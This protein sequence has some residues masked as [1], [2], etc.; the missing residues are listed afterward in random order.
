MIFINQ[1]K[2]MGRRVIALLLLVMTCV[3]TYADYTEVQRFTVTWPFSVGDVSVL[4]NYNITNEITDDESVPL[5]NKGNNDILLLTTPLQT[6]DPVTA[7]SNGLTIDGTIDASSYLDGID[8]GT[9]FTKL[10]VNSNT[11]GTET[12]DL[13]IS[14]NYPGYEILE[15][16]VSFMAFKKSTSGESQDIKIGVYPKWGRDGGLT[17]EESYITLK[18]M[19]TEEKLTVD[20]YK[21][22]VSPNG[23]LYEGNTTTWGNLDNAESLGYTVSVGNIYQLQLRIGDEDNSLQEGDEIYIGNVSVIF[24]VSEDANNPAATATDAYLTTYSNDDVI[25]SESIVHKVSKLYQDG[26]R[27][28]NSYNGIDYDFNDDFD[29]DST[30]VTIE[31]GVSLQATHVYVDTIYMKKG[32]SIDL[33]VPSVQPDGDYDAAGCSINNYFRWFNYRNDKNFYCGDDNTVGKGDDIRK[34]LLLPLSVYG[35]AN[36]EYSITAYRFANGY[37][38][39]LLSK[40]GDTTND[41]NGKTKE[42]QK[43]T[44][45]KVSFYYPTDY[46]YNNILTKNSIGNFTY[47]SDDDSDS[48]NN[49]YAVACDLSIYNDFSNGTYTVYGGGI[50]FGLTDDETSNDISKPQIYC[51]PTLTQRVLFYIIGIDDDTSESDLPE[52]FNQYWNLISDPSYHGGTNTGDEKYLEE[53]EI[54][55]PSKRISNYTD[56]LVALSK[57]AQSYALPGEND[58]IASYLDIAFADNEDNGFAFRVDDSNTSETTTLSGANRV[59]QFR[60]S[61]DSKTVQ[62]SVDNSSTATILVTKKVLGVTYNIARYK[63][64]FKDFAIPL[65]EPQVAILDSI[66]DEDTYWWKNMTYRAQSYMNENY[67]LVNSLWFDYG[68]HDDDDFYNAHYIFYNASDGAY[69]REWP[70][71]YQNYPFPLKWS[72]SSYGFYDGSYDVTYEASASN[73]NGTGFLFDTSDYRLQTQFCMY[74]IVNDY[75]GWGELNDRISPKI[76]QTTSEVKNHGGSWLYID[77]SDRPGTVAELEFDEK[78]CKGSEVIA[79]A[80]IKSAGYSANY[81]VDDAAVMFTIMGVTK[82]G[83]GTETHTPIYRQYS[84]QIRTTCYL[85]NETDEDGTALSQDVSGKGEGTNEWFQLYMQ[86]VNDEE[87][88]YDYYTVRIDNCC[89]STDGG[90]YYL[91]EISVYVIHPTVEVA[92]IKPVCSSDE[93][94]NGNAPIRLDIDYESLM[95]CFGL[96]PDDYDSADK[97][98]VRSLDFIIINKY[99][100]ESYLSKVAK[101]TEEAVEEAIKNSIVTLY[102]KVRSGENGDDESTTSAEYPTLSFHLYYDG[103]TSYV[104]EDTG[105][106]YPFD[107]Y[108]YGRTLSS[109]G[110]SD[111][112]GLAADFY[113]D[114]SAYT[115]YM[116]ILQVHNDGQEDDEKK[117]ESFVDWLA[118]SY[119]CAIKTDFY[120]TSTTKIKLNGQVVDPTETLC[121]DQVVHIEPVGTY[122]TTGEDDEDETHIIDGECFDWFIGYEEEFVA[123]NE[124][125]GGVSLK[126][127]LSDFRTVYTKAATLANSYSTYAEDENNR[128]YSEDETDID[129]ETNEAVTVVDTV[130]TKY[131]YEIL[132]Y[133]LKAGRLALYQ[134]YLDVHVPDTGITLV[135]QPIKID[136]LVIKD[137][138]TM[139]CFGYVPL[140][141]S[142]D[143]VAPSLN[144]GFSDLAYPDNY[145]PCLRLGLDQLKNATEDHPITV[146]LRGATYVE[147]EDEDSSGSG[148]GVEG[149]HAFKGSK[150]RL[151][152]AAMREGEEVNEDEETDHLG[153]IENMQGDEEEADSVDYAVLYLIGTNDTAYSKTIAADNFG[154]YELAVGK[155]NRLFAKDDDSSDPDVEN[156]PTDS[157]GNGIGSYMQIYFYKNIG[158]SIEGVPFDPKEGYYYSMTVHFEEKNAEGET[159][160][161]PCYGSFPLIVKVVPEYVV[162]QGTSDSYNWNDDSNWKRADS[163]DIQNVDGTYVTNVQNTTD[164][165]YVPMLFT[166]VVMPKD[167]KVQLYMGAYEDVNSTYTWEEDADKPTEIYPMTD[168]IEYDMMVYDESS[169]ES[170]DATTQLTTKR[171][172]VNLCDEIHLE[173]GAQLLHAEL[174]MYNK[175]WMDIAIPKSKWNLMAMPLKDVYVGDWYTKASGAETAEYFTDIDFSDDSEINSR[176][177]PLVYQRSWNSESSTIYNNSEDDGD[178]SSS[179]TSSVKSYASTGWSSVYN[180]ASVALVPGSGFSVKAY[181]NGSEKDSIEFRFPKNDVSYTTAESLTR[182]DGGK[183]W[184]SEMVSRT[185]TVPDGDSEITYAEID[186]LKMKT[187]PTDDGYCLVGNPFTASMSMAKFLDVNKACISDYWLGDTGDTDGPI[188]GNGTST[189]Y[190]GTD[191]LLPAYSAFFVQV[192]EALIDSLKEKGLT[193]MFTQD[194]QTDTLVTIEE[195]TDVMSIRAS[196]AAGMTSAAFGYSDKATDTYSSREDAILLEDDS[197]K[198]SGMPLV[199]TVAGDR[200]VSVNT[201]KSLNV[202]PLGVFADEGCSYTLT[203]VGVDNVEE[204]VLYDAEK[205]TE[206]PITE[207]FTMMLEGAT[208]GRYFIR[209][210][211]SS[212]GIEDVEVQKVGVSVY[213]PTSRTIV[214]SSDAEIESVEVYDIGGRMLKRV[215]VD[216]I[217][218][219]I[220]GINCDV[221]IVR[222]HTKQGEHVSKLKIKN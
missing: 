209:T 177:N 197:W 98:E 31:S 139:I 97:D 1:H 81:T 84:G 109:T 144:M 10:T 76:P 131:D 77:A 59:I 58:P 88:D 203:F 181:I 200:S 199:Y 147:E 17:I 3:G 35:D 116:I 101:E 103:N 130:F 112:Q 105:E 92:Q 7:I 94:T 217:S 91:D 160:S 213:S 162:W 149:V 138:V 210:S 50:D 159:I 89:A 135:I 11:S 201:L 126:S 9:K 142:I 100:Y 107:G 191:C 193:V 183:L 53:Y 152:G 176:Y 72:N 41:S 46:E 171:Y 165:G 25:G 180:D 143:G 146:N 214:V 137:N 119:N 20:N 21:F 155:I 153:K 110:G 166:K 216:G 185:I 90:D 13:V 125:Y 79:T 222:C 195:E 186:T 104:E 54:T 178:A 67:E 127:S 115:T 2:N 18:E 28:N 12:I 69:H 158:D 150:I 73:T 163:C 95:G 30:M 49:Y 47:N 148:G 190:G 134:T 123:P 154:T 157:E 167:S 8:E 170:E 168:N 4:W 52:D 129:P 23:W 113:A 196:N 63:L 187:T 66:K 55:F 78:L 156:A 208:H 15:D 85:D 26:I 45:R 145:T 117:L 173:E 121:K 136:S 221:A 111:T 179:P 5:Y 132:Q 133:Y 37:V 106:N 151:N 61:G 14:P 56:E 192:D 64:T 42:E 174:L 57:D 206:T 102:Y 39:G 211:K 169:G 83:D 44:L 62:W 96:D 118:N 82:N 29:E 48:N 220:H 60:Q 188:A 172:R 205:N 194:M 33:L 74:N 189:S 122:V 71:Q 70:G 164:G 6:N 24:R 65:T 140:V 114:I 120:L 68:S 212:D 108:L 32:T 86:F 34:D 75:M 182:T 19:P 184:L 141:L 161:L 87:V 22:S 99:K 219:T 175:L 124:D 204:P 218:C 215:R 198:K 16:T 128:I 202:I 207:G 43:N 80:W 51:E 40:T 27:Y 38:S 93:D 36:G